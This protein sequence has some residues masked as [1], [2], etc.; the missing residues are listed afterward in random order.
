[1]RLEAKAPSSE[2]CYFEAS[3]QKTVDQLVRMYTADT[4]GAAPFR[5]FDLGESFQMLF[6]LDFEVVF[7]IGWEFGLPGAE[8]AFTDF[9]H[10][11]RET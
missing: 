6:S 8:G 4:V 1:M 9:G 11:V 2:P 3:L 10:L 7:H 5:S